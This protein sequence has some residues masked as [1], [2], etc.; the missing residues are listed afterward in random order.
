MPT[1]TYITPVRTWEV[2]EILSASAL[3][4]EIYSKI[5]VLNTNLET[6]NTYQV[7]LLKGTDG[8]VEQAKMPFYH[9]AAPTGWTRDATFADDV[10]LR[11]TDGSTVPPGADPNINGGEH[12]GGWT[13]IGM[14][15]STP[16]NHSHT[17]SHTHNL[18]NHTHGSGGHSHTQT[19]HSHS[20][21]D[22]HS[23]LGRTITLDASATAGD[24]LAAGP[25]IWPTTTHTHTG[26]NTHTINETKA[27][28]SAVPTITSESTT[29]TSSISTNT[30][31]DSSSSNTDSVNIGVHSLVFDGL[32]RP[33]YTNI[34]ICKKD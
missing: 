34:I 25:M 20:V 33:S 14:S 3:M 17:M 29:S 19:D 9:I 15:L 31:G 10:M 23:M 22:S 30:S 11:V 2:R 8:G 13:I 16:S 1:L 21:T 26:V 5:Q 4:S 27:L 18:I 7:N 6:I 12:G 24:G 32:W 28:G